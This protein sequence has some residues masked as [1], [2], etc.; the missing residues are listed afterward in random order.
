MSSRRTRHRRRA[1]IIGSLIGVIIIFSFVIT[2]I[3]PDL[4]TRSSTN[5]IE[6][7]STPVPTPFIVPTPDPDPR[8]DGA[9]PYIH[10][11]GL[12]RVFRPASENWRVTSESGPNDGTGIARVVMQEPDQLVVIHNYIQP[13]VEYETFTS[14]SEN[15]LTSS[16]F[17]DAWSAYN[18]Y[19][20]TGRTVTE[21]AVIVDFDLIDEG[22]DYRARTLHWTDDGWFYSSRIVAPANNP[23]LLDLLADRILA[24]FRPVPRVRDLP[25]EWPAFINPSEGYI[26]KYP[27]DWQKVAGDAGR[28]VTFAPAANGGKLLVRTRVETGQVLEDETQVTDWLAASDETAVVLS[29]APVAYDAAQGY[30]VAYTFTDSAGDTSSGVMV[31]LND[32]AGN[33]F[34][35]N[36]QTG[37]LDTDLLAAEDLPSAVQDAR[38]AVRDGFIVLPTDQRA[39]AE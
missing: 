21:E 36:L 7:F 31:L 18:S 16:H 32:E 11:S 19:I 1:T 3:A 37:A 26:L 33:L 39:E 17:A 12:F 24:S 29:S 28:P 20:E 35:A 13:G 14:L 34:I 8:L 5:D 38:R 30:E 10:S 15:F 27:A 9:P 2:L 23:A 22:I 6:P 25:V 4:G